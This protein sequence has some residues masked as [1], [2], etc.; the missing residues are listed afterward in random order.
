MRRNAAGDGGSGNGLS[1]W[2]EGDRVFGA[3]DDDGQ[4]VRPAQREA[5][6]EPFKRLEGERERRGR[7]WGLGLAI[8][9]RVAQ[10]HG[11]QARMQSAPLG[12]ARLLID[13]PTQ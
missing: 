3:V 10:A 13:W 5:V 9:R 4:G 8:V 12:G 7:G 2:V 11:G 1:A 6:F